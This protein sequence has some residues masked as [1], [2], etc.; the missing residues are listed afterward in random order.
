M[1][2]RFAASVLPVSTRSTMASAIPSEIMI[3]T[4]PVSLTRCASAP[5]WPR[6]CRVT[7]GKLVAIRWPS[8]DAAS[9]KSLSSGTQIARRHLPTPSCNRSSRS[10]SASAT[11]SLPVIPMSNAP[12]AH[13]TGISSVRRKMISTGISLT[14]ANS[15]RFCLRNF[16]PAFFSSCSET[17]AKRPLLG[18]PILRF[19]I[20]LQLF[21]QFR[22]CQIVWTTQLPLR[23]YECP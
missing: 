17:S 1:R 23:G 12:S 13:R 7:V 19:V 20:A 21:R 6:Y 22:K 10:T 11:R 5:C 9:L 14:R 18:N 3:S 8:S 2:N 4:L 15:D 16:S